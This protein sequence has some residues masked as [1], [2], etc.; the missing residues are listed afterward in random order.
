MKMRPARSFERAIKQIIDTMGEEEAANAVK[1]SPSLMRKWSDPDH[2]ACPN[3]KQA[4][5]LDKAFV[6][7]T[8]HPAPLFS[9]YH[10]HLE[11]F[12]ATLSHKEETLVRAMFNLQA[13]VG[14]MTRTLSEILEDKNCDPEKLTTHL[15]ATL[16]DQLEKIY[17]ET[18]DVEYAIQCR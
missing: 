6:R 15:R 12:N 16:I 8:G 7:F 10:H 17:E 14:G 2:S 5:E 4:L 1:R 9:I 3:V 13:A 18:E 11:Q